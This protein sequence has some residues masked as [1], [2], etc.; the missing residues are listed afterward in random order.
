M[1]RSRLSSTWSRPYGTPLVTRPRKPLGGMARAGNP[2]TST[3][4][5]NEE[6][7]QIPLPN[8]FLGQT[9]VC[10]IGSTLASN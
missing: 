4:S 1:Q 8:S 9:K 3:S 10:I 6:G 5:T 2:A 7:H